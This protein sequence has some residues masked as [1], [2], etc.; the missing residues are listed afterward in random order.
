MAGFLKEKML[1]IIAILIFIFGYTAISLEHKIQI[2]KSATALIMGAILWLIVPFINDAHFK[3]ELLHT[4]SEIF[5]IVVFL[6]AAMSLVEILVHYRFFDIIRG[7]IFALGLDEKKQFVVISII[8]FFLSAIVDNLTCTI[9][10]VQIAKKFFT[11]TNLLRAVAAVVI[12]ANAGGAFSPIGDVTTIMLWLAGKFS[13]IDII[14][15][16]FLPSLA[17][18]IVSTA[19]FYPRLK[20][21][22]ND[23][24][25]EIITKL[26]RSE[27]L[28]VS[29][30]FGS[31]LLPVILNQIGLPPYLGLLLG[32]GVVWLLIDLLKQ[33]RPKETH[34]T[35]SIDEFIKKTDIPSL[36]FFIGILLAVSALGSMGILE[37]IS[38]MLYGEE[39]SPIRGVAGNV[40]LGFLSAILDNVPLTAIAIDILHTSDP[41][42][43]VLLALTVGMGGSL[44]IIGSAAGVIA[45]GMV[46]E[47]N[48][49]NYLKIATIPALF[50]YLASIAVWAIQYFIFS[51]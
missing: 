7:K 48:F 30:V 43:W 32:L 5:G 44:L 49:V 41:A 40:G 14:T 29:A 46:K 35:A 27:K 17:M 45:M 13:A 4:G 39:F 26:G 12:S 22:D 28:I 1:E 42:I 47:I 24:K 2:S 10:M 25:S 23:V 33:F 9:V 31:F 11:G 15:R 18:L 37:S 36:K 50:G 38:Q 20:Q 34:L 3:Q 6:L 21:A 19:L 16:G 8:T 51:F